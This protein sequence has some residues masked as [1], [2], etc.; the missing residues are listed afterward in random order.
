MAARAR[1]IR[2]LI[3]ALIALACAACGEE[4]AGESGSIQVS[5]STATLSVPQ[6]GTG[7]VTIALVR[8]G[9]FAGN[10]SLAVSGLPAGVT[11]AVTPAQLTGTT[12]SATIN[13]TVAATVAQGA[14]TATITASGQGVAQATTTF[15]LSVSAAPDY[16]LTLTSATLSVAAGLS[17]N[18]TV[19][20]ARSNFT[21]TVALTLVSPTAGIT[22]VFTPN[23]ATGTTSALVVS[24]AG[25]VAPGN[26]P[27]TIQGSATGLPNRSATL[28]LTVT[29]P[30]GGNRVE[31]QFCNAS[32]LPVF[33]AYQDGAGAWQAVAGTTLGTST[34][35]A[36]TLTQT[37]GGVMIVT[38]TTSP[39][40]FVSGSKRKHW[41]VRRRITAGPLTTSALPTTQ[42]DVYLTQVLYATSAELTQDASTS[43]AQTP[44]LK[45]VT[46]TVAGVPAGAY[47]IMSFGYTSEIFD[48]SSSTNPVTFGVPPGPQ[49]LVGSR[50][51]TPGAAPDKL[52]LMRNLNLPDGGSLP[53][54]IDFNGASSF[55][56]ATATVTITGAAA[57]ESLET[58]VD[59]V[60]ANGIGGMWSDLGPSAATTR[61]WAGLPSS[62]M[63]T[64]DYH[65]LV[66]FAGP[67]NNPFDFRVTLRFVG[68]VSNQTVA[69]APAMT[70]PTTAQVTAGA[71][72]R[73]RF[74]GPRPAEYNSGVSVDLFGTQAAGNF[75]GIMATSAYLAAAG[76]PL[77]YDFT[78]PDISG[79]A[80]FPMASRLSAGENGL[81]VSGFGF[82]AP[83][84]FDP[85]P[86]LGSEFKAASKFTTLIVP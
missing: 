32:D 46:G 48:G 18:T 30:A 6:G 36:F 31:Y 73:F 33:F 76:N 81:I 5:V 10:V 68:P 35:F 47:G 28:Q 43:C 16:T 3:V 11:A 7:S 4:P 85:V 20:I 65:G 24:V 54:P 80:G 58:F 34:R 12:A 84:I 83:G 53:A 77:A 21:G 75:Y 56:P 64:T 37:R 15:Q 44:P 29:A 51:V 25:S 49:D 70:L 63:L 19:N 42:A 66:V 60:T 9:G 79:I 17:G 45:T 8:S 55:A 69:L 61:T 27:L 13:V 38:Q 40:A 1:S 52:L 41:D 57:G 62:V 22:G 86:V 39:S 26:Y 72:P 23:S 2:S 78:M 82:N 59:L 74:Q 50:V 71:Y 67:Q 14:H